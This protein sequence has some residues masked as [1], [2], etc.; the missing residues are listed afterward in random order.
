M[1]QP[2]VTNPLGALIEDRS[3]ARERSDPCASLCTLATVDAAGHPQARTVVLRE[4]DGRLAVFGNATSPKWQQI[5]Q[6]RSLAVVVWLPSLELQYRLQCTTRPVAKALLHRSWQLRPLA[7]KRLDWFY[8]RVQPQSSA[9]DSRAALLEGV[10]GL[11]LREPL[12]APRTAAGVY[13]EPTLIERLD[14]GMTNG[15]HDRRAF[16][17][18]PGGWQEITLVP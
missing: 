1:P 10:N 4:L 16:R 11:R 17:H 5:E 8:T 14:L 6:S 15:I 7:P 18:H 13:L 12:A 2:A 9:I 3:R